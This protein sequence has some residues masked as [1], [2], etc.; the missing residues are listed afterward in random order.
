MGSPLSPVLANIFMEHFEQNALANSALVPKLWKRY[1]D[2]IF[3][4]WSHGKEH[5]NKFLS[6]LNIHPSIKFTIEQE[7]DQLSLSFLDI[8]LTRNPDGSLNHSVYR[9]PTHTD[10]Y[11]NYRSFHHPQIKSSVC[12]T[13]VNRAY[14]VCDK[15]SVNKELAH[16]NVVL[17]QNGF[18]IDM[19]SLTPPPPRSDKKQ[20]FSHSVSI[21]YV[22]PAS[23]QIERI[24]ASS[25]I[26]VYHCFSQKI[27]QLLF[28]HKDKTNNNLK[29]GDTEFLALAGRYTLGKPVAI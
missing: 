1:V 6:Y 3:A 23:H 15:E 9:K 24:L 18:P 7:N 19:I 17:Q 4:V 14:N 10:R 29:P 2:D 20:E 22:G 8:A 13:L 11:L 28:S 16:L 12:K 21:P 5:L 27:Y 25:S 26:K